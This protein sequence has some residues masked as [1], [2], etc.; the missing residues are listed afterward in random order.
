[1]IEFDLSPESPFWPFTKVLCGISTLFVLERI[2]TRVFV[3]RFFGV[4]DA[5]ILIA[6]VRF[7]LLFYGIST[8]SLPGSSHIR[9]RHTLGIIPIWP[10]R[11]VQNV[12]PSNLTMVLKLVFAYY[13]LYLLAAHAIRASLMVLYRRLSVSPRFLMICNIYL[14]CNAILYISYSFVLLFMCSPVQYYWDKTIK[15]ECP[16]AQLKSVTNSWF[17]IAL[18]LGALALPIPALW[19]MKLP[20]GQRVW[21][22]ICFMIG[23]L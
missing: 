15:G 13:M 18:D 14:A 9:L 10:W 21:L 7:L 3:T 11:T 1:M 5:L 8:D 4:E 23:S 2:Y 19:K 17:L 6:M 12:T 16:N 20:W 22:G